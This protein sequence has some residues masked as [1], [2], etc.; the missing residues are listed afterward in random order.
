MRDT[1][2]WERKD[3]E[4]VYIRVVDVAVRFHLEKRFKD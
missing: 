2:V 4:A 3:D 1:D